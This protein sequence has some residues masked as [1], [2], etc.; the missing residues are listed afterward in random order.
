MNK[1]KEKALAK[2]LHKHCKDKAVCGG[3][4][5]SECKVNIAARRQAKIFKAGWD[6]AMEVLKHMPWDEAV[7]LILEN[8][9][10]DL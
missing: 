1:E 2:F 6:A 4:C 5:D 9:E 7:N 10:E 3:L 8:K